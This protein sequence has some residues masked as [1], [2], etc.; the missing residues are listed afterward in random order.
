MS[1]PP[2][3]N[4]DLS[5]TSFQ[6]LED[7]STAY[8]FSQ[9]LFSAVELELFDWIAKKFPTTA[10]LAELSSCKDN[11]LAR[12][13]IALERM[14]LVMQTRGHWCNSQIATLYL[15]RQSPS[16]MG[17]FL[18]YRYYM[19]SNWQ[20]LSQ[21]VSLE[22]HTRSP[23]FPDGQSYDTKIF[24]YARAMDQLL[25]QKAK[26]IVRVLNPKAWHPPLLDV[27][28]GAGSLG[29]ALLQTQ[30]EHCKGGTTPELT[31]DLLEIEEVLQAA[32]KIYSEDTEWAGINTITG[33][34]RHYTSSKKYGLVALSNFLHAYSPVE[35]EQLLQKA[36]SLLS[37]GGMIV[38]HDYFPDRW[39]STPTKAPLYDLAMM[40]NT[41]NG[42]CHNSTEIITWLDKAGMDQTAIRDLDTDSTIIVSVRKKTDIPI[43]APCQPKDLEEW[44][45][46]A[47]QEG[48]QGATIVKAAQV[49][50][51]SWVRKKCQYGC[52]R[53]G[54]GLQCPPY[55]MKSINT[56]KMIDSY[57]WGILVEG[58]PPGQDFHDKLLALEKRAFLS[59]YHKAFAFTAGHCPVCNTCPNEGGCRFPNKARPS[60][61]ASGIDV[62]ATALQAGIFLQPVQDNMQYV[63]YIGLLMLE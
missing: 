27:G 63:K 1:N 40:L 46:V 18:L 15:T 43:F 7:L 32:R 35:A 56:R 44:P 34:F 61:E 25:R 30:E 58:M 37:P 26:D 31:D 9:A 53:Y 60:M 22:K 59:G 5:Q 57:S 45:Y 50:T 24:N 54:K 52:D 20:S 28:G 36:V 23:S 33:D 11:E 13:M 49:V 21:K 47:R 19:Q 8:W 29:R 39:G 55:G 42:R 6:F 4:G 3:Q 51:G 17:D 2:F 48:F 12:L 10:E 38:I 41:F 16:Y 14:G 62:Y